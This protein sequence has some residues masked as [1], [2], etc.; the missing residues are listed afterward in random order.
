MQETS[1]DVPI[2][3]QVKTSNLENIDKPYGSRILPVLGDDL[4]TNA[5]TLGLVDAIAATIKDKR[6]ASTVLK[7]LTE[8]YPLLGLGHIKRIR[9]S[10]DGEDRLQVLLFVS[11]SDLHLQIVEQLKES[12]D[13]KTV[14]HLQVLPYSILALL[15]DFALVQVATVSPRTR[16]QFDF[17][18]DFWPVSFHEDKDITALVNCSLFSNKQMQTIEQHMQ[19][20]IHVAKTGKKLDAQNMSGVVVVDPKSDTVIACAFN[21][22]NLGNSLAS[23]FD[24]PL[25]HAVMVA[26][27]LVA[28]AQG[29][30]AYDFG[31]FLT[32]SLQPDGNL[33]Y[34][35]TFYKTKKCEVIE[36][37]SD[38]VSK[39]YYICTGLDLYSTI[40][41][42]PMCSMALL[43][44]RINR[45]FYGTSRIAGGVGS[46]YKIHARKE[47]NHRFQ[48]FKN[49][50]EKECHA[51]THS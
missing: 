49:V 13:A 48:V 30:G 4:L 14:S 50:L 28:R 9:R 15:E 7:Y 12:C 5:Q 43:H 18:K 51:L 20:A 46:A 22:V 39:N 34:N 21:L 27:D 31:V 47:F 17:S 26:I 42:C 32:N 44:S 10:V 16:S 8:S 38:N 41:P 35:S 2:P 40:E 29:G 19:L 6:K 25:Q 36:T 3:K 23:G 24:H 45:V 33:Y 37:D 11:K 1:S